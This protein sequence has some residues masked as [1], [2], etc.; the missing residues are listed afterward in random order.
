MNACIANTICSI[1]TVLPSI[2]R[3]ATQTLLLKW[4]SEVGESRAS[5]SGMSGTGMF[6][7]EPRSET[8][9]LNA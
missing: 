5:G 9:S 6:I 8:T 3:L 1:N 7:Y 2:M 4:L